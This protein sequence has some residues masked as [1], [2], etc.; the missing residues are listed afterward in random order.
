MEFFLMNKANYHRLI[1]EEDEF[2]Y[3]LIFQ[4]SLLNSRFLGKKAILPLK[5][6]GEFVGTLIGVTNLPLMEHFKLYSR[7]I[8]ESTSLGIE[9]NELEWL[10]THVKSARHFQKIRFNSNPMGA[11]Y[12][13][14]ICEM[15]DAIAFGAFSENELEDLPKINYNKIIMNESIEKL[16]S[17]IKTQLPHAQR[18]KG[19]QKAESLEAKIKQLRISRFLKAAEVD[20]KKMEN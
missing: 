7:G 17:Y 18:Q 1:S 4:T 15:G 5:D 16:T 12:Y 3:P 6:G 13:I 2:Y 11:P 14:L 20:S 9:E 8:L 19:K 10:K